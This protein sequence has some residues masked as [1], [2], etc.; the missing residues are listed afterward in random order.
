MSWLSTIF[1]AIVTAA[2]GTVVSGYFANLAVRWYRVSSFEGGSGYFVVGLALCGLVA[3]LVI[4]LVISRMVAGSAQP[5]VV[6]ALL[7]SVTTM[8][9]V[10]GA[11]GGTARLLADIP[12]TI[13][14]ETLM[15]HQDRDAQRPV[16]W[17]ASQHE[18]LASAPPRAA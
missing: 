14:G 12:P 8:L 13:D 1:T 4:G 3:G 17:P 15:L 9:C 10:T 7:Y 18:S 11:A 5:S 2:I 16:H 6:M